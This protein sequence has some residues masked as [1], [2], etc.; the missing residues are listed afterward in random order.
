MRGKEVLSVFLAQDFAE[1]LMQAAESEAFVVEF[2]A[3]SDAEIVRKELMASGCMVFGPDAFF[4]LT[5][6]CQGGD[7]SGISDLLNA[8]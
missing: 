4:R 6:L 3:V 8:E 5:V 7:D 1:Y 2:D